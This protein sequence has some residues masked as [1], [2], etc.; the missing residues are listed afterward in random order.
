MSGTDPALPADSRVLVIAGPAHGDI[1]LVTPLLRAIR[2]AAPQGVID[3]L[4][5]H[6][7]AAILEGNTDVDAV[8][9]APKHPGVRGYV[10]LMRRIFRRYDVAISNKQTDRVIG[11]TVLAG[12]RRLAVVP[13]DRQPWKRR[14]MTASVA[15]DH[16]RTHTLVQN[17]AL[18]GLLGLE[19][20]W[21]PRLPCA[22]ESAAVVDELLSKH[23][24][25]GR[26]AVLHINPG[27]PHKRWTTAGWKAVA[28]ELHGTGLSIVLTGDGSAAERDY[29]QSI[30]AELPSPVIDLSGRLRFAG[31]A[32]LLSR[33]GIFVGTDTV[34]TH[35]AAAAGVPTV[36]LFGPESSTVWGPWPRGHVGPQSPWHGAGDQQAGNVHLLQSDVPCPTCRQGYCLRRS[37]RS[38]SCALMQT[39]D[40]AKAVRAIRAILDARRG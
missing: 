10:E 25:A 1:L 7:Q 39:L 37:E 40:G 27:L 19:P 36:A 33:S 6:G 30:V 8:L 21:E 3:V 23:A 17:N 34:T 35:M 14:M 18:G 32:E 12:R 5:Y 13:G 28:A 24:V 15:Y 2:R 9:S 29:L 16:D 22:P 26:F 31:V 38:R 4:V 20:C 11:Y